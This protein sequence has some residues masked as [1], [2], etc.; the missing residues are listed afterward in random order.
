M[1]RIAGLYLKHSAKGSE[2]KDHKYIKRVDG[3]YYYPDNYEGGRHL[4]DSQ[5]SKYSEYSK[6]DPDFDDKNYDDKNRLGDTDF[7]GFTKPDGTVVILEEDMKWTLPAGTKITPELIKRLEAFDKQ[8]EAKRNK[9]EKFTADDWNKMAKEAI[10]G[11]SSGN[12]NGKLS[13]KDINN[14]AKEVIRGNFANGNQRKELL[15]EAYADIQKKV[16]EMLK[17]SN[18]K[19]SKSESKDSK[20]ESDSEYEVKD[21]GNHYKYK[22]KK[23]SS[24]SVKHSSDE[25]LQISGALFIGSLLS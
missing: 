5:K 4:S 12:S 6:D 13:D 25:D 15:G 7:Y 22:A 16:N 14:L 23:S 24:T 19:S 2:W 21:G 9:G 1:R 18:S 20:K 3:T 17:S 8:V 10:D 11:G